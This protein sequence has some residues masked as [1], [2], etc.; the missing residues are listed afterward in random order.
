MNKGEFYGEYM[1]YA[2]VTIV[3]GNLT[4][5]ID[6]LKHLTYHNAVT[7]IHHELCLIMKF[8][9]DKYQYVLN[10]LTITPTKSSLNQIKCE[11]RLFPFRR[12]G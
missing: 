4:H 8:C 7:W 2:C 12:A 6:Y 1:G 3:N 9:P 5:G 10:Q 11:P